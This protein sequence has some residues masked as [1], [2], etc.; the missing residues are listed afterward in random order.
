MD[1]PSRP[2]GNN[3]SLKGGRQVIPL[4]TSS[5]HPLRTFRRT[6]WQDDALPGPT[7]GLEGLMVGREAFHGMRRTLELG[8]ELAGPD[9]LIGFDLSAIRIVEPMHLSLLALGARTRTFAGGR[10]R[11][12][13]PNMPWGQRLTEWVGSCARQVT[14]LPDTISVDFG[15]LP[16]EARP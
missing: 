13:L 14:V 11:Y 7:L 12:V 6:V 8:F 2:Y 4:R 9:G 1:T 16:L 3:E 5:S 10:G 15:P